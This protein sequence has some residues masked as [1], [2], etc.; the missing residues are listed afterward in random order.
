MINSDKIK[1]LANGKPVAIFGAGVSGVATKKLLDKIGIAS[2][3]YAENLGTI[4]NESKAQT[5]S[6]VVYSPAFR[7]DNDWINITN[8]NGLECICETDLS[9]LV[10]RGKIVAITGT[11]GKTTL[12]KFITHALNLA[13]EKAIAVGNVGTPLSEICAQGNFNENTIAVYELSS[14]QTLK[15]KYLKPDAV[16]WTNFD[17]DHLDW[18]KD[19]KEYFTAKLNLANALSTNV[20]IAGSSVKAFAE[21]LQIKLPQCA[22]I[23]DEKNPPIAPEPF[24]SKIQSKNYLAAKL[25]WSELGLDASILE[26]ACESFELPKFRFSHPEKIGDVNFFNDSKATN[27]HAAIAAIEE[28]STSSNLIWLGGGKDKLCDLSELVECVTTH[29]KGAVL[30]GQTAEKLQNLLSEKSVKSFKAETMQQAVE[31]CFELASPNGDVIFS[32]AFSSF[33]MFAGYAER[34]KSFDDAVLCLKNSKKM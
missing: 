5:H 33:G 4:F 15:L 23:F 6:L 2:E 34:G 12:T 32:P 3:I 13:G 26:K 21:K 14:F 18:H 1:K 17:S 9:S 7:P 30:I 10:W 31:M 27:A 28:L 16:I 11:N 8:K 25:L 19:L 22:K 24:S 20:F 29:C